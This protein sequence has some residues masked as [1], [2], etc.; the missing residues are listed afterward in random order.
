MLGKFTMACI[1]VL[2]VAVD[3]WFGTGLYKAV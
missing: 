2:L 3:L 1:V